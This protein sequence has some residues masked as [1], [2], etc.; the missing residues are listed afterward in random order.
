[1]SER[2]EAI[3][4]SHLNLFTPHIQ[5]HTHTHRADQNIDMCLEQTPR[6]LCVKDP[7]P[8]CTLLQMLDHRKED[9]HMRHPWKT[10]NLVMSSG[11]KRGRHGKIK[12]QRCD[13]RWR[14][15]PPIHIPLLNRY[16]WRTCKT[17]FRSCCRNPSHRFVFFL[18]TPSL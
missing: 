18:S 4:P 9:K 10:S 1:M 15:F 2:G 8:S 11:R 5:M 17:T 13:I 7:P 16:S 12:R 6:Q 14:L 3:L